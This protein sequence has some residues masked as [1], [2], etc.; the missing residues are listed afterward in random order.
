M[1]EKRLNE[2]INL[3]KLQRHLCWTVKSGTNKLFF[4]KS[5]D[6]IPFSDKQ[7]RT[8]IQKSSNIVHSSALDTETRK[9]PLEIKENH[10]KCKQE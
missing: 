3:N 10:Y 2:D 8:A 7:R 1:E 6:K 9:K 5:F 4:T